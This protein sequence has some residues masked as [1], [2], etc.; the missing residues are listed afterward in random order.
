MTSYLTTKKQLPL[1]LIVLLGI[2]APWAQAQ[3]DSSDRSPMMKMNHQ[4]GESA[5]PK[6]LPTSDGAAPKGYDAYGVNLRINDDPLLAKFQFDNLE[7]AHSSKGSVSQQ[8]DGR[9]WVGHNLNK[10]WV[11][12]E[13]AVSSGKV[14]EGDIEAL[15]GHAVSPFWDMM[16]GVRH[17]FGTGP[18]RSWAAFG[19]QGITPYEYEFEATAYAGPSGRTAFRLKTSQDWLFT[20]KLILTPELDMNAYGKSDPARGLGSG[21]TDASLSFRL[22][23]EITRKFAPYIG[24]SLSRKF[25]NTA[26]MASEEGTPV[27]DHQL[28][29]GI[30]AWF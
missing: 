4:M 17:D 11:R 30:R 8:W 6:Q 29:I 7:W 21:L 28:L 10:L 20:Q 14:E 25:G 3:T 9:F 19:F 16:T 13:G 23:Y 12:S 1:S 5:A 15:W 27:T 2:Y 18:E 26:D 22:R 24:Y